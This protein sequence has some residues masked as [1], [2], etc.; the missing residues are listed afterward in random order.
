MR[1]RFSVAAMCLVVTYSFA[2]DAFRAVD[3]V[4]GV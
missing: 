1:F 2:K 3:K 4:P